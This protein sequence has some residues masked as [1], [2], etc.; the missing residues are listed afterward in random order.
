MILIC[1]FVH[2]LFKILAFNFSFQHLIVVLAVTITHKSSIAAI[3]QII[4]FV[5]ILDFPDG[6]IN[7][8]LNLRLNAN[9]K[10]IDTIKLIVNKISFSFLFVLKFIQFMY[11]D[12]VFLN[13]ELNLFYFYLVYFVQKKFVEITNN[14]SKFLNLIL[15]VQNPLLKFCK[16]RNASFVKIFE[17]IIFCK[18]LKVFPNALAIKNCQACLIFNTHAS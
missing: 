13:I 2:C 14:K 6:M 18:S 1:F 11:R 10:V 5:L 12:V 8:L 4:G 16:L 9:E 7:P 3:K 15:I 17:I